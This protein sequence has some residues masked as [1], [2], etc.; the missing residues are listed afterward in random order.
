[1]SNLQLYYLKHIATPRK[2]TIAHPGSCI[3]LLCKTVTMC[4]L[5]SL[6]LGVA[7]ILITVF[8][9]ES[10]QCVISFHAKSFLKAERPQSVSTRLE[11]PGFPFVQ[12][13]LCRLAK[14][15]ACLWFFHGASCINSWGFHFPA[16]P[17][18]RGDCLN[19]HDQFMRRLPRKIQKGCS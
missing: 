5:S 6:F 2:R 1:M 16:M 8:Q 12:S 11:F 3:I 13:H 10:V 15:E 18:P 17:H 14:D 19:L 7:I 4:V 9:A